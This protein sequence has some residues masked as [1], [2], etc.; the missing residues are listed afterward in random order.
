MKKLQRFYE[1]HGSWDGELN[2]PTLGAL[3]VS[4]IAV[5]ALIVGVALAVRV[6]VEAR[7]C[8]YAGRRFDRHTSFDVLAGCYIS[9]SPT[10]MVPLSQWRAI[11]AA[12]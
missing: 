5:V 1:R 7:N 12:K 4:C 2:M 10:Q 11:E 8:A 3:V 9:I 6:G